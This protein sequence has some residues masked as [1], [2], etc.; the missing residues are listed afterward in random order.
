LFLSADTIAFVGG[1]VNQAAGGCSA[2][3]CVRDGAGEDAIKFAALD[4]QPVSQ[5]QGNAY[6]NQRHQTQPP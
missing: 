5:F 2:P 4:F 6:A 1:G 3:D